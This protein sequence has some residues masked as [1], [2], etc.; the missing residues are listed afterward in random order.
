MHGV[1]V[2]VTVNDG[3]APTR[4]LCEDVVPELSQAPGFVSGHWV[5]LEGGNQGTAILISES[6]HA[7]GGVAGQVQ[8]RTARRS[9]CAARSGPGGLVPLEDVQDVA[10]EV[11]EPER[12]ATRERRNAAL[13]L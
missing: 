9:S 7:A 6:D 13:C 1:V 10:V 5:R 3:E 2:R 8:C 12:P 4:Y 11:L